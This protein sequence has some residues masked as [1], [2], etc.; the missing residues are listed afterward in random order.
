M[1]ILGLYMCVCVYIYIYIYTVH[2]RILQETGKN[3]NPT[4]LKAGQTYV[5]KLMQASHSYRW[6]ALA[7][8]SL[9]RGKVNTRWAGLQPFH[10][11]ADKWPSLCLPS[12][13]AWDC[14]LTHIWSARTH[15]PA[16]FSLAVPACLPA[17]NIRNMGI[18]DA[19]NSSG[20]KRRKNS[21][22]WIHT[23]TREA[24]G[25]DMNPQLSLR[26]PTAL[27]ETVCVYLI[28]LISTK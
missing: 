20:E 10:P 26:V 19:D 11:S 9:L 24:H 6:V 14:I 17:D 18:R 12:S 27:T 3:A 28:L 25:E 2:T 8:S 23:I 13:G 15:T 5:E 4:S 7:R 16:S 21:M 1:Y 22:V